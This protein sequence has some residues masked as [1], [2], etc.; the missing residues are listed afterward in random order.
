MD[1]IDM[2]LMDSFQF[3]QRLF[4][5][6]IATLPLTLFESNLWAFT[7]SLSLQAKVTLVLTWWWSLFLEN[8]RMVL[9]SKIIELISVIH[10]PRLSLHPFVKL[11]IQDLEKRIQMVVGEDDNVYD[12]LP[13]P[14]KTKNKQTK[15]TFCQKH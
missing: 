12:S 1:Y 9:Q 11:E 5:Q 15:Q 14:K 2:S 4:G 8:L 6:K 10:L 3:S 13:K 7:C